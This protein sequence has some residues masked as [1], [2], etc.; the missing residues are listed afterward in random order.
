MY[1]ALNSPSLQFSYIILYVSFNSLS[2]KFALGSEGEKGANKTRTTFLPVYSKHDWSRPVEP[3]YVSLKIKWH[4]LLL[5]GD[6]TKL[7]SG[8]TFFKVTSLNPNARSLNSTVISLRTL[9]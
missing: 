6:N 2:I 9:R 4:H 1:T 7:K 3:I 8:I 5:Q